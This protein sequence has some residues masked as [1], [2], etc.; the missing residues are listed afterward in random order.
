[1]TAVV[2]DMTEQEMADPPG[3]PGSGPGSSVKQMDYI[4]HELHA[5]GHH[6]LCGVCESRRRH[7][8]G[9]GDQ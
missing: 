6:A 4:F 3:I 7:P 2:T 9:Q 5:D 1:M 8:A